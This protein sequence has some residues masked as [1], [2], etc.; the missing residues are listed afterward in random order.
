MRPVAHDNDCRGVPRATSEEM[1]DWATHDTAAA[2]STMLM[3]IQVN[4]LKS[5]DP[6]IPRWARTAL[7]KLVEELVDS[8]EEHKRLGQVLQAPVAGTS[9]I[10][11][12][13]RTLLDGL[14][15][16]R[17]SSGSA[18]SRQMVHPKAAGDVAQRNP[19]WPTIRVAEDVLAHPNR[20]KLDPAVIRFI[21]EVVLEKVTSFRISVRIPKANVKPIRLIVPTDGCETVIRRISE[22]VIEDGAMTPASIIDVEADDRAIFAG[23]HP[24]APRPEHRHGP[25]PTYTL[26]MRPR[27]PQAPAYTPMPEYSIIKDAPH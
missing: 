6:Y 9:H 23:T 7:L 8:T 12:E 2:D 24:Y 27:A 14:I 16:R 5:A 13:D 10:S 4:Y 20:K 26:L 3:R 22:I 18:I 21:R 17:K 25:P 1:K 11:K 15:T 19:I